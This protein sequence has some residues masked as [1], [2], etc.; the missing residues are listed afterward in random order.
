MDLKDFEL[1]STARFDRAPYRDSWWAILKVAI[2][3]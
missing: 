1:E 2:K 3:T